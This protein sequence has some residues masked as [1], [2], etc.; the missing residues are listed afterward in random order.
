MNDP[1]FCCV[2]W[3]ECLKDDI[4]LMTSCRGPGCDCVTLRVVLVGTRVVQELLDVC[5]QATVK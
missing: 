3:L 1:N 5:H 2:V 4:V